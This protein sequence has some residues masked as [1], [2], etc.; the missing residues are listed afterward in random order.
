MIVFS[1]IDRTAKNT[2]LLKWNNELWIIDNGASF[3]FHHN[4]STWENHL[5]RTFPLIKDHVLLQQATQLT[6]AKTIIEKLMSKEIINEIISKIP[7]DW[8]LDESDSMSPTHKRTAYIEYINTRL[9]K[10]D[11]LV[12]EATDAR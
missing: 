12:K 11:L 9:S 4:W 10:I 5:S 2:N 6:E 8:L 7:E 3:Y 1:N